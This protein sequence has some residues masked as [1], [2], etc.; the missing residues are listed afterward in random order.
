M[1]E[2]NNSSIIYM[3]QYF[4]EAFF[5]LI[6]G[7][8]LGITGIPGNALILLGFDYFKLNDYKSILGA[9]LFFNLFPISG[10]SVWEFYKAGK[11]DFT[12][13]WILL[14]TIILGGYI[15]S[16]YVV[17]SKNQLTNKSIKYLS[18]YFSFFTGVL[19]LLSA[20]YEKN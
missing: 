18:A 7:I 8:I 15:G 11:I 10:G 20:Y 14:I 17:S 19:F 3:F 6:S 12:M 1:D 13:G 5:G 4:L 9:I 16:K 2:I